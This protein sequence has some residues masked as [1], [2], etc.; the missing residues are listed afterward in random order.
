MIH[1]PLNIDTPRSCLG[2]AIAHT[3]LKL[4]RSLLPLQNRNRV[5]APPGASLPS[6]HGPAV[7]EVE[8]QRGTAEVVGSADPLRHV[9]GDHSVVPVGILDLRPAGS[10]AKFRCAAELVFTALTLGREKTG[11]RRQLEGSLNSEG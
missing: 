9:T 1:I 2:I 5:V 3:R 10:Q 7:A 6:E 8:V 4:G 11:V